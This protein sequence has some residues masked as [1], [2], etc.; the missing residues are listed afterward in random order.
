LNEVNIRVGQNQTQPARIVIADDVV[1]LRRLVK[2][3]LEDHGYGHFTVV[4]EA[5]T[6]EEAIELA[7]STQPDLVLLDLSMPKM[8]GLETL[9]RIRDVAPETVI[10]VFSGFAAERMAP[11]AAKLGAD[12]YIEKGASPEDF[13]NRLAGILGLSLS[14]FSTTNIG[15]DG[16]PDGG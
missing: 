7:Q 1:A 5:N 3:T 14:G 10:V 15:L 6:G 12:L 13:V 11:T 9:P 4:G 2:V 8:D 16:N